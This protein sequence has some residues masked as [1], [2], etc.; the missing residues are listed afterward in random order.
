MW[1]KPETGT[2]EP[3]ALKAC[4][5]FGAHGQPTA[6]RSIV[7]IETLERKVQDGPAYKPIPRSR[8]P[9]IRTAPEEFA[10]SWRKQPACRDHQWTWVT[11]CYTV[12][13]LGWVHWQGDASIHWQGD[14]SIN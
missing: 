8:S 5:G 14:A 2:L 3:Q 13:G 12:W 7:V 4:S 10:A 1:Q 9:V 11:G 6:P